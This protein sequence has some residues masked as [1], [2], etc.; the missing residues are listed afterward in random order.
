[1]SNLFRMSFGDEEYSSHRLWTS[2]LR[3]MLGI[4]IEVVFIYLAFMFVLKT[5]I[6]IMYF[7]NNV[8]DHRE[9]CRL[10]PLNNAIKSSVHEL[11]KEHDLENRPLSKVTT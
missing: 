2:V 11:S 9:I 3:R 8:F 10:A 6:G 1:M 5:R 7:N 4:Y